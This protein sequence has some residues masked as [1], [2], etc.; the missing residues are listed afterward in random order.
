MIHF[1]E[2]APWWNGLALAIIAIVGPVVNA[3]KNKKFHEDIQ[4]TKNNVLE[5]KLSING[6]L[7]ELLETTRLAAQAQGVIEGRAQVNAESK[8]SDKPIVVQV[9]TKKE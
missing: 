8:M 6:R 4:E 7:N 2:V 1:P 5:V 3:W 9:N